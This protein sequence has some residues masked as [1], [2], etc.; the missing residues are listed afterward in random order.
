MGDFSGSI[1]KKGI[2]SMHKNKGQ[3]S[4]V[5]GVNMVKKSKSLSLGDV[6]LNNAAKVLSISKS[7]PLLKEGGSVDSMDFNRS[8]LVDI[9]RNNNRLWGN[10]D[11]EAS[12]NI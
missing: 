5:N 12:S 6:V 3:G 1:H 8:E 4:S 11:C 2:W 10:L 9:N 7:A